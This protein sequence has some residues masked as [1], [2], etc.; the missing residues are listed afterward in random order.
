MATLFEWDGGALPSITGTTPTVSGHSMTF[1][2]G[3][4]ANYAQWTVNTNQFTLRWYVTV[5]STWPSASWSILYAMTSG[6]ANARMNL[7][8]SAAPGQVRYIR[9]GNT[10]IVRSYDNTVALSTQYRMEVQI[11]RVNQTYRGAVF[12]LMSET[13]LYDT[14]LLTSI[15]TGA[16]AFTALRLGHVDAAMIALGDLTV[17]RVKV[18][19]TVG[20]WVGRHASDIATDP[21]TIIEWDGGDLPAITGTTPTLDSD[22]FMIIAAGD[23]VNY[24][25]WSST[26]DTFA[27]RFYIKTPNAWGSAAASIFTAGTVNNLNIDRIVM[28]GSGSPGQIRFF[29][30]PGVEI[31]RSSTNV[32]STATMYRIEIRV[33]R[34]A[35]TYRGAVFP[36]GSDSPLYDT[37]L[38]SPIDSGSNTLTRFYLGR[39]TAGVSINDFAVGRVKIRSDSTTWVGRHEDDELLFPEIYGV[40]DGTTVQPAELVGVWNGTNVDTV[41]IVDIT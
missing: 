5:P 15:D 9:S 19:D 24:A 35:Q 41:E 25:S 14:G 23:T 31:I 22:D 37:G 8:G 40:W 1:P 33:D 36:L 21:D 28:A 27:A 7:S 30:N 34:I 4:A 17:G 29:A 32:M 13:P 26:A 2:A 18:T 20:S 39:I 16:A 10:E 3:S 11:D 38:L 6:T 12:P